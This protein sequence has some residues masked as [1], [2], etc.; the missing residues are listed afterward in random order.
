MVF[1]QLNYIHGNTLVNNQASLI[2]PK[3]IN[4]T[5]EELAVHFPQAQNVNLSQWQGQAVYRFTQ[6]KQQRLVSAQT[7]QLL[8]PIAKHTAMQVAKLMYSGQ[9]GIETVELIEQNAPFELNSRHLPVWRVNFDDWASPTL[10]IS[11]NSGEVVTKRHDFWRLFDWMF[12][13]HVMD[14]QSGEDIE[15]KLLLMVSL[16][17]F[18]GSLSGAVLIYYRQYKP[19][20][21]RKMRQANKARAC[22]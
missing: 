21:Q 3:L 9:G 14:Y 16:L 18:V 20:R 22:S 12:R 13:F 10:Y 1:M 17:T 19:Y 6:D 8:S 5:L 4:L 2:N 15:N 11:V 7:G